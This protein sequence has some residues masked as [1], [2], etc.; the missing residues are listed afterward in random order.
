MKSMTTKLMIAAA[1]LAIASGVASAQ[2]YRAD[3]PF[4]FR[5][6]NKVMA[7]GHYK[8]D[9][10]NGRPYVLLANPEE[11]ANAFLLTTA[12]TRSTADAKPTLAFE[13]QASRCSLTSL[14]IGGG[15]TGLNFSRPR[16]TRNEIAASAEIRLVRLSD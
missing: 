5:A 14:S 1:A 12:G 16:A 7:P 8:I 15:H 11:K 10:E 9:V 3:I 13:C 2:P 4:A 6:G